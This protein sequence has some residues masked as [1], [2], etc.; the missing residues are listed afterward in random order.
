MDLIQK[1]IDL[2]TLL[3]VKKPQC[4]E[5][6]NASIGMR[7]VRVLNVLQLRPFP[8]R[9]RIT[10]SKQVSYKVRRRGAKTVTGAAGMS[11]LFLKGGIASEGG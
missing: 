5:T 3:Q 1:P 8:K 9:S 2:L 11:K 4:I 10:E 7:L 6:F